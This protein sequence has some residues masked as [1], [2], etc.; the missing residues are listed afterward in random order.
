[1]EPM[2]ARR[3]TPSKVSQSP[4]C[5]PIKGPVPTPFDTEFVAPGHLVGDYRRFKLLDDGVD[6]GRVR[7]HSGASFDA[8]G[9]R[10]IHLLR[11]DSRNATLARFEFTHLLRL[12]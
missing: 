9:Y 8:G 11:A 6:F 7:Y 10:V 3:S 1:H 4:F 12:I 2:P 5:T